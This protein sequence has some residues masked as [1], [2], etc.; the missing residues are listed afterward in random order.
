LGNAGGFL[1]GPLLVREPD[2]SNNKTIT[3]SNVRLLRNDI[4]NLMDAEALICA[5]LFF[6]VVVYFPSKPSL[7]PS[8]T[9]TVQRLN[10]KEGFLQILKYVD[11]KF[12]IS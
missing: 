9:S 12:Y 3:K 7:P 6:C 8:L 5:I 10:I 4:L 11:V 1:L 2:L